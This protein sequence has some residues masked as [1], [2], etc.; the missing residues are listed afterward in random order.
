VPDLPGLPAGADPLLK[1]RQRALAQ[2]HGEEARELRS[3]LARLGVMV[4]DEE[5][6]QH[7]RRSDP[8]AGE[9]T[10]G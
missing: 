10:G 3:E 4:R 6:R 5:Q 1:A 2:S 9:G 7:V 8:P